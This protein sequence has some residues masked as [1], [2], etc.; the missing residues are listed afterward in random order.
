MQALGD[1]VER[2]GDAVADAQEQAMRD[3]G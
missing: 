3:V 1:W 2:Y